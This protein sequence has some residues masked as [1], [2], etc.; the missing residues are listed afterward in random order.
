MQ[1]R[2]NIHGLKLRYVTMVALVMT[3]PG[4]RGMPAHAREPLQ[5]DTFLFGVN[6]PWLSWTD[7]FGAGGNGGVSVKVGEL[8]AK[9]QSAKDAGMHVIRWWVFEGGSPHIERDA[10]GTPIGLDPNVYADLDVALAEADKFDV[11]Y[12]FVLFGGTNDDPITHE[13]W[14][15][16]AKRTAL[17]QV[18]TPLFQNYASNA[19]VYTWEIVNE[20]ELQSRNGQ[21]TVA[22]MLAT[23]DALAEA[24]H[25]N[26]QAM[27]TVG[28]TQIEDMQT[29]VGHPLD[30][31]SPHYYDHSDPGMRDPFNTPASAS[32]PDGKPVVI[33][34]FQASNGLDPEPRARWQTLYASGYAGAWSWS[35]SPEHAADGLSTDLAAAA[36][37]AAD[38]V[39]LGPTDHRL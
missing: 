25:A 22:G 2:F 35:L 28:S 39:D 5:V 13:W 27:V 12:D 3:L 23:V 9:L 10:S 4:L 16:E 29:W 19:R 11:Y 30:Y 1:T 36:I 33:G 20:P 26:S 15:D 31:Y 32:T 7:D 37:F 21:T 38:K 17:V 34:E 8:D 18:L 14:E 24:V 6:M